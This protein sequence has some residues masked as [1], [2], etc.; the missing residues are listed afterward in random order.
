MSDIILSAQRITKTY[1]IGTSHPFTAL[2]DVSLDLYEKD[3]VCIM[4]PSGAGKSTL[5]NN[6]STID[7]PTKGKVYINGT[8]V[9]T[10]GEQEIGRFRYE[11][12]GFIFQ[13]FNLLDALTVRENIVV[14]LALANVPYD[15][16]DERANEIAKRLEVDKLLDKYPN[17]CSGG[18]RQRIAIARALITN[19]KLI[20]ADEPTGNLD[21]KNSHEVLE[22]FREMNEKDG[23]TIMMVTHDSEIASYSHKLLYIKDGVIE[24][25]LERGDMSQKDYFHKIVDINSAESQKFMD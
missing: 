1:G 8:E 10:L 13:E 3:F 18:Q 19:P 9:R 5:V 12:L 24:T 11:N 2:T 21:S 4:G 15:E 20:I 14:P 17:E 22:L 6:L 25:S 16:M 7:M 23:V